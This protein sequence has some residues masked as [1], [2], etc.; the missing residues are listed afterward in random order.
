M[1]SGKTGKGLNVAVSS[2]EANHVPDQASILIDRLRTDP[3]IDFQNDWKLVTIFVGQRPTQSLAY[4]T[5]LRHA[6]DLLYKEVPQVFINLVS[7]LNPIETKKQ[8]Y[9]TNKQNRNKR[10]GFVKLSIREAESI[11]IIR[12]VLLQK[13]VCPCAA[14]PESAQA[15]KELSEYIDGYHNYIITAVVNSGRR[16]RRSRCCCSAFFY[17]F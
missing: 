8:Y 14:Y 7:V 11:N 17:R 12:R 9:W 4:S 3:E 10:K 5:Y 2:Q 13:R 6:L 15:E 16:K 1:F